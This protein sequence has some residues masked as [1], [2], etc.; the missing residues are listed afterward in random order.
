MK[1]SRN[2][3]VLV[4][5]GEALIMRYVTFN[6]LKQ[7]V[8]EAFSPSAAKAIFYHAGKRCGAR[9]AKR[10]ES[11]EGLSDKSSILES[12]RQLKES[13][14]WGLFAFD[15]SEQDRIVVKV[16]DSFEALSYGPSK[17]PVCDFIRGY[18]SGVFSH[19]FGKEIEFEEVECLSKGDRFCT[20]VSYVPSRD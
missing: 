7:G 6:E 14:G 12:I 13:Q 11:Q 15:I 17:E 8:E 9:A 1:R 10:V 2:A 4:Q 3:S 19:I 16:Q 5:R 20:F 18:L